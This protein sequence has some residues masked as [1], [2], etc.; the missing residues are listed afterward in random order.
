MGAVSGFA[1]STAQ[2]RWKAERA[3]SALPSVQPGRSEKLVR[4]RCRLEAGWVLGGGGLL[5]P[6]SA[7]K[8]RTKKYLFRNIA[9]GRHQHPVGVRGIQVALEG[10]HIDH[11]PAGEFGGEGDGDFRDPTMQRRARNARI[12]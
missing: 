7:S 11:G 8:A 4:D 5:Q 12:G 2:L 1:A 6:A 10:P 9:G 3:A